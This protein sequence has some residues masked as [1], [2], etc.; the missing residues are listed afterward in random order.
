MTIPLF[1]V[2]AVILYFG[3][4]WHGSTGSEDDSMNQRVKNSTGIKNL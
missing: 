2:I 4:L 3:W 1:S